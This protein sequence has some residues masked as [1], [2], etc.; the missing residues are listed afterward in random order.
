MVGCWVTSSLSLLYQNHI[1]SLSLRPTIYICAFCFLFSFFPGEKISLSLAKLIYCDA[2]ILILTVVSHDDNVTL[3]SPLY[4]RNL[5]SP[6]SIFGQNIG[7]FGSFKGCFHFNHHLRELRMS[8]PAGSPPGSRFVRDYIYHT[9][10]NI[11]WL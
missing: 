3:Q 10:F 11:I 9:V 6:E 4:H 8:T 5:S 1:V 2:R 7:L